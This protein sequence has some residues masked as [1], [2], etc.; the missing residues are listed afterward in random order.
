VTATA[1]TSSIDVVVQ[2]DAARA[3]RLRLPSSGTGLRGLRE[4]AELLGGRLHAAEGVDGGF[5]LAVSVPR[6][7]T[8]S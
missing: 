1:S 7:E 5:R 2:N 3:A 4:R 6:R 8:E